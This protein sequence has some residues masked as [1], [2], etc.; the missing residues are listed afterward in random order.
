MDTI[1]VVRNEQ[2]VAVAQGILGLARQR[3]D[4]CTYKFEISQ[5]TDARDLNSLIGTLYAL[6]VIDVHVRVLLS[7]TG[8]RAGLSRLN[9][10]TGKTLL[11]H[12]I[13]VRYLPDNRCQHAK[14]LLVD[15]CMGIIGSHNWSPKS[16]TENFEVSVAI[17][18]AG[19]LEE[20]QKHFDKIWEGSKK[21]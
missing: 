2:F 12:G 15:N 13:D 8:K 10:N 19:Y 14:M 3:V 7:I 20:I 11:A 4:I 1:K 21:L 16:M 5:R 17:N 18:H 6:V 9:A